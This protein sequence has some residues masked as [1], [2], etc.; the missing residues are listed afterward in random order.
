M[1]LLHKHTFYHV[2]DRH[3]VD[4]PGQDLTM[5]TRTCIYI[6][7]IS[8]KNTELEEVRRYLITTED[9]DENE[10]VRQGDEPSW[11]LQGYEDVIFDAVPKYPVPEQCNGEVAD[12]HDD[13]GK[14]YSFP[15]GVLG[16]LFRS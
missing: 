15:H 8:S 11:L 13:V 2:K 10:Y 9:M 4:L 12:G 3:R 7:K 14:D 6:R 5:L 16:G 1:E